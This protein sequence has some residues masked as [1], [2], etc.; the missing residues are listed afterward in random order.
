MTSGWRSRFLE[1]FEVGALDR[2]HLH[3]RDALEL[4]DLWPV[5]GTEQ[6]G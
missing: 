3:K 2:S 5:P 6:A 1:D 4:R